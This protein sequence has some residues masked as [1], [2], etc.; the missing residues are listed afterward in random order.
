MHLIL[1]NLKSSPPKILFNYK[2]I[3]PILYA[4]IFY[5]F[6]FLLVNVEIGKNDLSSKITTS[7]IANNVF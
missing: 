6:Y 3:A 7:R 4:I 2:Y 5:F 1:K